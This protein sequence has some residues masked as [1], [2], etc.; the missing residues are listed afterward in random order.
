METLGTEKAS[1]QNTLIRY[2][3]DI[4]WDYIK[5]DEALRLRGG[6]SGLIL[7]EIFT[8]QIIKL[9]ADFIDNLMIDDL[10]K[11]IERLPARIDGNLES[12]EY[13][14]GLKTVFLPE[15]N[16]SETSPSS[17]NIQ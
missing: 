3:C 16:E 17:T 6:R 4:G 15:K 5:P 13:L 8:N 12:W 9:N 10:I 2:A 14:K 11:R 1:V 7:K